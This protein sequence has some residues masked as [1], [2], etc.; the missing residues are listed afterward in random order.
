[1]SLPPNQ[2]VL[3]NSERS[4]WLNSI[5]LNGRKPDFHVSH[6]AFHK[7]AKPHNTTGCF[8]GGLSDPIFIK[9]VSYLGGKGG[10]IG[11]SGKGDTD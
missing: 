3:V 4:L 7:P 2:P 8:F 10:D 1:M 6:R 5:G 9:E 11:K